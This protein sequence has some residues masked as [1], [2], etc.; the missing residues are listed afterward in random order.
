VA[1]DLEQQ[2]SQLEE[3]LGLLDT[4]ALKHA[5]ETIEHQISEL[6]ERLEVTRQAL[7][8]ALAQRRRLARA[9]LL[10]EESENK[11]PAIV[12]SVPSADTSDEEDSS[13]VRPMT[14]APYAAERRRGDERRKSEERRKAE[15]R[16][17]GT[18]PSGAA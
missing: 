15:R 18:S 5:Q 8:H 11:V 7:A 3:L 6:N 12:E 16:A 14:S 13:V 1:S 9:R 17:N 2:L 4:T 10:L